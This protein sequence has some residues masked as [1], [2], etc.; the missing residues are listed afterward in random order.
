MSVLLN[1]FTEVGGADSAARMDARTAHVRSRQT[2]LGRAA[3]LRLPFMALLGALALTACMA[4]EVPGESNPVPNAV[5][6]T[7]TVPADSGMTRVAVLQND[8]FGD[9]GPASGTLRVTRAPSK[10]TATVNDGGT[11]DDPTDDTVEYT[12]APGYAGSDSFEYMLEDA[13]GDTAQA[14]VDVTVTSADGTPSAGDDS[15]SVAQDSGATRVAVL[16]NDS[17]GSDGPGS[18]SLVINA[19]PAHGSAVVDDGGTA[20]DPTDDAVNY[21]PAAGY[22]GSDAFQYTLEDANGDTASATVDVT[23]T[24]SPV[25]GMPSA[26]DDSVSVAED[27]GPVTVS[28]LANDSFGS[29]GPGS[30]ALV[31]SSGPAH[32]NAV[33]NHAGTS[34]DPT[35]DTIEYT[36]DPGYNGSD[37]FGYA[38]E[39]A[40]GDTASATVNVTVAQ[41]NDLPSA[42]GDSI[43]VAEDSTATEILVLANDSF[44]GDGPASSAIRVTRAPAHGTATVDD[45]GT[46]GDPTDDTIDYTPDI[47]FNGSDDFDYELE[48]GNGDTAGATVDVTVTS[49]NDTPAASDDTATVEENSGANRI[50][51]LANDSFGGDGPGSSAISISAAPANGSASVDNGGTPSDPTD[52]AVDYVPDTDFTGSDSFDY[53]FADANGDTA[54][55]SV[56]VSVEPAASDQVTKGLDFPGSA[57]VSSTMRFRFRNPLDIYPATYIWR[58]YPRRQSGYYTAFF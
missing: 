51:V 46:S 45:G 41:V 2:T 58:A 4:E 25:D 50:N 40:N 3:R 36:P 17:F 18:A 10:G 12:P 35:D 30:T 26:T 38:I 8:S 42:S 32:G 24:M 33:V 48:D 34:G 21:T 54:T 28:V 19:A 15:V 14:T 29:D 44:G 6:D 22:S 47:D 11:A 55:A 23:V 20:S 5:A 52:D 16:A 56:T 13:T 1:V 9:D 27:G 49:V 37:S 31:L 39:D 57:A 7:V 53:S 43:T